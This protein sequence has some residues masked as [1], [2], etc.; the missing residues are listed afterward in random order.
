[1][2]TEGKKRWPG[3]EESESHRTLEPEINY[4]AALC[5]AGS[6]TQYDTTINEWHTCP[7]GRPDPGFQS[8][9]RIT[10]FLTMPQPGSVN[11][12]RVSSMK[13]NSLM[14]RGFENTCRLWTVVLEISV[15]MAQF[16]SKEVAQLSYDYR[17]LG[18]GYA[19]LGSMLMVSGIAYDSERQ[20]ASP[21]PSPRS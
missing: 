16:P 10:C 5:C 11:L 17:T 7:E 14:C 18:L 12:R 8:L 1:M 20:E 3:D 13:T 6:G 19:N 9:Q 15:L 2:G 21:A 4:A